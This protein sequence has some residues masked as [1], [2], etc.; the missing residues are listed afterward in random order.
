MI[1]N[2]TIYKGCDMLS[3]M[4][5][6]DENKNPQSYHFGGLIERWGASWVLRP[7]LYIRLL[8]VRFPC[9]LFINISTFFW[10]NCNEYFKE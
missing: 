7:G 10:E 9:A 2:L 5:A 8:G 3:F 4:K 1:F 6:E